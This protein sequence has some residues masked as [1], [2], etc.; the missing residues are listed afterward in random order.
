MLNERRRSAREIV[1]RPAK[2]Q[3]L[4]IAQVRKCTIRDISDDGVRLVVP[5]GL[6][7]SQFTLID[8][9]PVRCT[10]IWRIGELVGARFE[11]TI[12]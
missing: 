7:S 8:G 9:A 5:R 3:E 10:V 1:N 6:N 2:L 12:G 11:K 4:G